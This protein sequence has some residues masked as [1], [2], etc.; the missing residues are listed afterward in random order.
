MDI[1]LI[2]WTNPTD[3]VSN[4]FS[5]HECLWLPTWNRMANESDGL[6]DNVKTNLITLCSKLDQ[7]RDVL[8][9]SIN[10]HVTLRP[11]AYNQLI[12]GAPNSAHKYGKACDFDVEGMNCDDVR[13]YILDNKVLEILN[14]R[15]EQKPG[16]N[17]VHLGNDWQP[18]HNR[19]FIP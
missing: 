12:G 5:V 9:K 15:M 1:N 2:D 17:W 6:D 18:G 10:V 13:Q 11:E 16:S 19:Y 3:K 4:H 7:L 14:L 8:N